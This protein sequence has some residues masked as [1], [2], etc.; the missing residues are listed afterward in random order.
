MYDP[1]FN[2][3][4]NWQTV[5]TKWWDGGEPMWVTASKQGLKTASYFWHG[6]ETAIQGY[7]PDIYYAYNRS[8]PFKQRVDTVVQWMSNSTFGID[9]ATLYFYQPDRTGHDFGPN[10][11]Q[12]RSKVEEMDDLLGYLV[13][14]LK[15]ANVLE[16]VNVIVT[17]DHGMAEIDYSTRHIDLSDY[18]DLD[19]VQQLP[20][21]GPVSNILPMPNKEDEIVQNLS[22]VP[23]LHV[24]R[25]ADIPSRWHY[26][27]HRRILPILLVADEGWMIVKVIYL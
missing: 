22:S 2:E 21:T 12:I 1:V 25:K 14:E 19:A 17:S 7:R 15:K 20:T 6:S 18:I 10:S 26:K 9:L 4:F 3:T 23:H 11:P 8:V 5:D 27:N 13:G 24:Y 16:T